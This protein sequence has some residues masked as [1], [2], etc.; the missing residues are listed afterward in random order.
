MTASGVIVVNPPWTLD[1]E[2]NDILPYLARTLGEDGQGFYRA[3]VL[4]GE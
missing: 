4:A 1:S 3:D 2:M